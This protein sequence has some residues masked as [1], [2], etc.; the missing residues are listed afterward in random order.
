MNDDLR[1]SAERASGLRYDTPEAT[2]ILAIGPDGDEADWTDYYPEV[3]GYGHLTGQVI[4]GDDDGFLV[5]DDVAMVEATTLS[6]EELRR[7]YE[8]WFPVW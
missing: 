3:D 6:K 2:A 7:V 4:D 1:T 8:G 5:V